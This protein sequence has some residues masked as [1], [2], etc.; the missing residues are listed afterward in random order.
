[1][2]YIYYVCKFVAGVCFV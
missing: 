1:M 2:L